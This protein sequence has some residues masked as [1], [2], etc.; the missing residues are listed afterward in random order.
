MLASPLLGSL[1]FCMVI[2]IVERFAGY[3]CQL[4]LP[5]ITSS[6]ATPLVVMYWLSRLTT[7]SRAAKS[8]SASSSI[9]TRAAQRFHHFK[10]GLCNLSRRECMGLLKPSFVAVVVFI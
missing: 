10:P 6:L 1:A 4:S 2:N 7:V 3:T 9:N 5:F 8:Y